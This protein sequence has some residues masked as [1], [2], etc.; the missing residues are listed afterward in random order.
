MGKQQ[1]QPA[2]KR[3]AEEAGVREPGI[4][5]GKEQKKDWADRV[6]EA[7]KKKETGGKE[8]EKK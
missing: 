7:E 6:E 8:A 4:V 5:P 1:R 3:T 2:E